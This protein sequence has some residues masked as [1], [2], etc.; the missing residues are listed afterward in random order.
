MARVQPAADGR[1]HEQAKARIIK[2]ELCVRAQGKTFSRYKVEA[3][4][5]Q[6]ENEAL[7]EE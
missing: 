4:V 2:S 1:L 6:Q 3:M 5:I 7:F